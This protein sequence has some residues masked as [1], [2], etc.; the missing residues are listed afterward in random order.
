MN[1]K[2]KKILKIVVGVI[3]LMLVLPPYEVVSTNIYMQDTGYALIFNLPDKANIKVATLITQWL[4]IA[5]VGTGLIFAA[6][7]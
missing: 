3:V 6:K 1:A 5:I 2:Q 4:G 7:D